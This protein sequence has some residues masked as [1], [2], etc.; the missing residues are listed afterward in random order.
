MGSVLKIGIL[1]T[2][3]IAARALVAPVREVPELTVDAVAS[4]DPERARTYAASQ[5]I[6]RSLDYEAL[7]ADKSVDIV[8]ITL[9]PSMHAEWSL[10]ALRAGKHVL[11]EKPMAANAAQA[12]AVA[13]AVRDGGRVYMEAFH[14]PYHP[15]AR[16][17]RDLLDTRAI[18]ALE[19]A[20]A[21]FQIPGK[22]IAAGNIRRQSAL[23]GGAMMDAGC[24]PLHVLRGLLGEVEE[25]LEAV[26]DTDAAD[27]QVDLSM[28]ATLRF[29]GGRIGRLHAS[30][31][32]EEKAV[33]DTVVRGSKGVL[34][35]ESL[36]VPQWGG[37]L[38]MRWDGHAYAEKADVTPSYVFQL[39][40][41]VRCVRDGAPV[42]TSADDG[43]RNMSAIDAIYLKAGLE[44]RCARR[45]GAQ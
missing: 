28:R 11:C 7:L 3:N 5:G 33:V 23:G 37:S 1:G 13:D 17:V 26:A 27:P 42:L 31:L 6:P 30:F 29:A 40:E 2:G 10:R 22:F 9:P 32:A 21:H 4:R 12:R 35:I 39:R 25:V 43:V 15:F 38:S 16:R 44:V 36:Y 14:Y 41:L 20:E 8:Y 19:S 18:G 24:Y 34:E 45:T